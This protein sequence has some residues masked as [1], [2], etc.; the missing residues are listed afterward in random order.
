MGLQSQKKRPRACPCPYIRIEAMAYIVVLIAALMHALWNCM[1]K[2]SDDKL[3]TLG[4]IRLVGLVFGLIV[5]AWA[6]V[7]D[8]KTLLYLSAS[9]LIF[10]IYYYFLIHAYQY[11]D[12]SVVYPISR[13]LAPLIVLV[14]SLFFTSDTF[15]G[16]ELSAILLIS[17][18]V[19]CLSASNLK[20]GLS[21]LPVG[22]ALFTAAAIAGYT[23]L[24]GIGVRHA[25]SFIVFSGYIEVFAGT[26]V[27]VFIAFKR[28]C[29]PFALII[30]R[31]KTGIFAGIISVCGFSSALWAMTQ[32]PIASV[33]A[34]RETSIIFAGLIGVLYFKEGQTLLRITAASAVAL[35]V[36]LFSISG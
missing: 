30:K 9:S 31:N 27:L 5:M 24:S 17:T 29:N 33:A 20:K 13:G 7:P 26:G 34:L 3:V 21:L 1:I 2:E 8:L 18:G 22:Y 28:K 15:S 10:F 14:F 36:V 35:G 32:I 25:G 16:Y 6:P 4:A 11:G 12:F 19:A 23:L